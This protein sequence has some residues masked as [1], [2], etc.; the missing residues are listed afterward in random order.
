MADMERENRGTVN[1]LILAA[2]QSAPNVDD[3]NY[4]LCLT[5]INGAPLI[6]HLVNACKVIGEIRI[7]AAFRRSDI[8]AF[9]L[10]NVIQVLSPGATIV[11][12]DRDTRGAACTAL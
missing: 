7:I 4:P 9:H 3:D 12:A 10:D 5:E 6:Q 2:G 11:S 1:V 8:D